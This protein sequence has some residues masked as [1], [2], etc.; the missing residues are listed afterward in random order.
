MFRCNVIVVFSSAFAFPLIINWL[1]PLILTFKPPSFLTNIPFKELLV[2]VS[3]TLLS[4]ST[5]T[6]VFEND[7]VFL[8]CSTSDK[9]SFHSL[10]VVG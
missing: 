1:L 5:S 10:T 4:A 6:V 2:S 3:V 9:I 7:G 8:Y